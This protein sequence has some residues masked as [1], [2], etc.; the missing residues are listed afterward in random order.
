MSLDKNH[1]TYYGKTP[2]NDLITYTVKTSER[3]TFYYIMDRSEKN[4][5]EKEFLPYLKGVVI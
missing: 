5:F 4:R 1:P 3:K 2:A